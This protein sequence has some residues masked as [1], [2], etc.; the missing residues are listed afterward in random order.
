MYLDRS[1]RCEFCSGHIAD[2]I[3][4]VI[5][6]CSPIKRNMGSMKVHGEWLLSAYSQCESYRLLM[7]ILD[8]IIVSVANSPEH[9]CKYLTGCNVE[10]PFVDSGTPRFPPQ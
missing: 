8:I 4:I 9:L 5:W 1:V 2:R 3:D 6:E 10:N 7:T